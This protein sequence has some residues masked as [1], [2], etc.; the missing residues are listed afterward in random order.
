MQRMWSPK[1]STLAKMAVLTMSKGK[2]RLAWSFATRPFCHRMLSSFTSTWVLRKSSF[3]EEGSKC[4]PVLWRG[5]Q[6]GC[7]GFP[8]LT[9]AKTLT[10]SRA[11][12]KFLFFWTMITFSPLSISFSHQWTSEQ[13]PHPYPQTTRLQS[14]EGHWLFKTCTMAMQCIEDKTDS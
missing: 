2:A 9:R 3:E 12:F 7:Q 11:I 8:P 1:T 5:L 4:W 13:H 10:Q 14:T 6:R